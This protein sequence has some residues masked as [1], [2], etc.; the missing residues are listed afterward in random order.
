MI[1]GWTAN[2]GAPRIFAAIADVVNTQFT[3]TAFDGK[4]SLASR[5]TQRNLCAYANRPARHLIDGDT[6]EANAFPYLL[7]AHSITCKAVAFLAHL[8]I[9]RHL[10]VGHI[11]TIDAQIP[12]DTTGTQH[13]AG[14]SKGNRLL[15]VDVADTLGT[16]IKNFVTGEQCLQFS[17]ILFELV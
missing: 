3:F 13:R 5:G 10:A 7:H 11:G 17:H 9:H 4:I 15:R 14:E 1:K 2:L 16:S 8:H 12:I 6:A